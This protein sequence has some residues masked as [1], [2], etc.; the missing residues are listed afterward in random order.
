MFNNND[1]NKKVIDIKTDQPSRAPG[2]ADNRGSAFSAV[3][4]VELASGLYDNQNAVTVPSD[5]LHAEDDEIN[6]SPVPDSVKYDNKVQIEPK[7]LE[8][9]ENEQQTMTM[10]GDKLAKAEQSNPKKNTPIPAPKVPSAV[11]G[12]SYTSQYL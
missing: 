5:I 1:L 10:Q 12:E 7:E 4:A 3:V 8:E 9:D 6:G 11:V 2:N